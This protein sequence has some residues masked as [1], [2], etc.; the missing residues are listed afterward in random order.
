MTL[1]TLS[2]DVWQYTIGGNTIEQYALAIMWFG[3]LWL[4]CWLLQK[5]ILMRLA[6]I[7]QRTHTDIDDTF[8]TIAEHVRPSVY[9]VVALYVALRSLNVPPA[10]GRFIYALFIAAL[11][12]Q[13]VFSLQILVKYVIKRKLRQANRS[14]EEKTTKAALE[15]VG[16]LVGIGL[17]LSGV[18]FILSNVGINVTSLIAS[19]GIGGIAVALAAQNVLSDLFSSLA[20]Y[21]D[22]PFAV[23]DFIIVG[24]IK[25]TVTHIG[26]KTTRLEAVG[27]HEVILSNRELTSARVNNFRRM[28]ERRVSFDFVVSAKTTPSLAARI[29]TIIRECCAELEY[30]RFEGAHLRE[31]ATRGLVYDVAYRVTNPSYELYVDIQQEINL[32]ILKAC[33]KN[34]ISVV[35][36]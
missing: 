15:M 30:V 12:Y 21:L 34:R 11:T 10:L 16:S 19:L 17:W 29:P 6:R 18:L 20:I 1:T 27:G 22:K 2:L 24:D 32:K 8:L 31:I 35:A 5:G 7:T 4:L 26:I 23:G 28:K 14:V 3:I 36:S 33:T 13:V 9:R 25:G